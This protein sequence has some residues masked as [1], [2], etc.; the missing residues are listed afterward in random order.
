MAMNDLDTNPPED[1]V[2][3]FTNEV[4]EYQLFES[5]VAHAIQKEVTHVVCERLRT[6]LGYHPESVNWPAIG[7]EL[8]LPPDAPTG[9]VKSQLEERVVREVIQKTD[10]D[11]LMKEAVPPSVSEARSGPGKN[12]VLLQD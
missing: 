1:F 9:K 3:N 5:G 4:M 7:A 10:F 11:R 12:W 8:G 6:R 2:E